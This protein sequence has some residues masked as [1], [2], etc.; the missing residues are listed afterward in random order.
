MRAKSKLQYGT[1]IAPSLRNSIMAEETI[2]SFWTKIIVLGHFVCY[3]KKLTKN[4]FQKCSAGRRT[5]QDEMLRK[6]HVQIKLN[7][8]L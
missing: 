6:P 8:E 4:Y 2:R 7:D 1:K 3:G 5:L